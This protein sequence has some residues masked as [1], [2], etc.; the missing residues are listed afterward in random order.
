M[1]MHPIRVVYT[2]ITEHQDKLDRVSGLECKPFQ[3]H[4]GSSLCYI[5]SFLFQLMC[6]ER[7]FPLFFVLFLVNRRHL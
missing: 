4:L 1:Q 6:T 5:V 7:W 2:T 3:C